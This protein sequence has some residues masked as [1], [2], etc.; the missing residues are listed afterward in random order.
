MS[1]VLVSTPRFGQHTTPPG[2]PERPERADVFDA[3]AD[4]W[5]ERRGSV[6]EPRPASF[7]EIRR[8]HTARHVAAIEATRG[9]AA[10]LDMDTFTSPETADLALLAAGGAMT[11]LERVLDGGAATALALV[12]PPGH[13]AEGDR[14]MG[15]CF[16]N[17]V[18]VAA[19]AALARGLSR[20]AIVDWDVHHGNGTQH[21]FEHDARV[22]YVSAHESPLY[23]GTGAADE[24]GK[25]EG[26]GFTLNIP[27]EGGAT[28][29]DYQLVFDDI[30]VPVLDR[31]GPELVL[32]SAGFDA[33]RSDPLA[34]MRLTSAGFGRVARSIAAVAGRHAGGRVVA[35][36]EGGYEL[37]ALGASLDAVIR[38]LAGDH[39]WLDELTVAA[40]TGRG[41]RAADR[42]RA[43]QSAEWPGL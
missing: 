40:P 32:V 6:V 11:A 41:A 24:I 35:V 15:F 14:A 7:D 10:M 37:S 29:G 4:A 2:H 33:H 43:A 27:L 30:I 16:Y 28:D 23:P 31:F 22:L 17:N 26:R 39:A 13:H 34:H 12:R 36:T 42:A 8:V 21:T 19:A 9:R 1:L 5:R 20:V 25:G 18:A 38:V 3:V